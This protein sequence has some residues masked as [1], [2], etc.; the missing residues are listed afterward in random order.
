M[1]RVIVVANQKGGV[2]KTTSVHALGEALAER[3]RR[4]LLVDLDPQAC[5]TFSLGVDPDELD[6]S[7]HH[8]LTAKVAIADVL[9]KTDTVHLLPASIEL[10]TAELHLLSK[11]GRE[12]VLSKAL[13]KVV[14]E[15]DLVLIDCPPSLGILTIN[16]LT[17]AQQVLIP[18][19]CETLSQRGVGQL[20][21]T[22]EDV[23]SYTNPE[24]EV[25]GVIATM[26]DSRTRL[27]R[28]VLEGVR[29]EHKLKVLEPPVPKSVRVAEAPSQGCSVLGHAPNSP[30][31]EAYRTLAA[32]L[33]RR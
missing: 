22:I 15:Y 26:Y 21:E 32:A 7:V 30:A 14:D 20:L 13:A 3:G 4:V 31:A 1:T 12:Y 24:L 23:R 28:E 6:R 2:A 19:Q 10:A 33:A 16:G 11:A 5:L 29:Q 8:V 27:G 18:L 25:R 9:V 17:A